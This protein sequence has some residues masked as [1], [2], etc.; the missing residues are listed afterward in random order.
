M[1]KHA[2]VSQVFSG[3]PINILFQGAV[4]GDKLTRWNELAVKWN[5]TKH[6]VLTVQSMYNYYIHSNFV[7]TN[8]HV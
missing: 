6:G 8:K 7:P 1:K 3:V 5:L 2:T 4:D